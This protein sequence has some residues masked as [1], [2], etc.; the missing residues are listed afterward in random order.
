MRWCVRSVTVKRTH[1]LSLLLSKVHLCDLADKSKSTSLPSRSATAFMQSQCSL[2]RFSWTAQTRQSLSDWSNPH[3]S[4]A[5]GTYRTAR[6]TELLVEL[7][8]AILLLDD[9]RKLFLNTCSSLLRQLLVLPTRFA[10]RPCQWTPARCPFAA[11]AASVAAAG[12][13]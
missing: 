1:K 9:V 2:K 8:V 11:T 7:L 5:S 3:G 12:S 10:S 4:H 6:R 13:L